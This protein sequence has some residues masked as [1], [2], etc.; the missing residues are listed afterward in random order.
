MKKLI[1]QSKFWEKKGET[2]ADKSRTAKQREIDRKKQANKCQR[3]RELYER[4]KEENEKAKKSSYESESKEEAAI[5]NLSDEKRSGILPLLFKIVGIASLEQS[6]ESKERQL[7]E[8][9]KRKKD[10]QKIMAEKEKKEEQTFKSLIVCTAELQYYESEVESAKSSAKALHQALEG[11][12]PL[13]AT[14]MQSAFFWKRME[15]HCK[16]LNNSKL[17]ETVA[18]EMRD[19]SDEQQLRVWISKSFKQH[20]VILNAGCVALDGVSGE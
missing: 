12:K 6:Q 2:E 8:F 14:M 19:H 16:A 7:H 1:T 3:K 20:V 15:E 5:E 11:L 9:N 18:K 17:K 13:T 4:A 10:A